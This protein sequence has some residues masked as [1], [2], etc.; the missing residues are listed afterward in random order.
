M[1][2]GTRHVMSPVFALIA[3]SSAHGGCWQGNC[4]AGSQKRV[5]G[6]RPERAES[7]VCYLVPFLGFVQAS[8]AGH[9]PRIHENI[10]ELWIYGD[11]TI[12]SGP[13]AVHEK[14]TRNSLVLYGVYAPSL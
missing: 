3:I 9:I 5:E 4:V 8:Y 14:M 2:S 12:V 11:A 7:A 13:P 10:T 6:A 1:S